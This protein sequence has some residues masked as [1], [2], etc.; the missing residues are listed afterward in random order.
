M[1][2]TLPFDL[3]QE[4]RTSFCK[5]LPEPKNRRRLRKTWRNWRRQRTFRRQCSGPAPLPINSKWI[6]VK[7]YSALRAWT[8]KWRIPFSR[9]I[10]P[11]HWSL[12]LHQER[13]AD[14]VGCQNIFMSLQD[15]NHRL[16]LRQHPSCATTASV[17]KWNRWYSGRLGKSS[18]EIWALL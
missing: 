16:V 14:I 7:V 12:D 2:L 10:R 5:L 18:E 1:Y 8:G 9:I 3:L 11:T 15:D 4:L 6:S 17:Q 13:K